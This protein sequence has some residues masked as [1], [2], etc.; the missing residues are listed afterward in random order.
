MENLLQTVRVAARGLR[1]ARAFSLAAIATLALGIGFSTAVFTVANALLLRPLPVV[2]QDRLVVLSGQPR[3]GRPDHYPLGLDQAVDFAKDARSLAGVAAYAYEGASAKPIRDGGDI[4]RLRR[5]LV[6]GDYFA[7]LGA[8]PVLGRQ[9]RPEDDVTGAAPVMVLSHGAWRERFGGSSEVIGRQVVMHEDGT[10]YTIVGVMP[11]GLDFPRGAEAWATIRAATPSGNLQY[12]AV[13]PIARLAPGATASTAAAELTA[14]FSRPGSPAWQG[15]LRG[16]ARALPEIL[17]GDTRPA[18]LVF[19]AAA[20]LLLLI[21]CINVANL[22]VVRGIGRTQEVAIRSALGA[23]QGRI[24]RQLLVEHS[25]LAIAG[26][27]LGLIVAAGAVQAFVDLAPS[28]IPRL[29]EIRL[30]A[31]ALAAALGLTLV[32]MLLFGLAPAIAS[33]RTELQ[34]VLRA[35]ARRSPTRGSRLATEALVVGQVA[36][37]FI[38]LA[39]AGLLARSFIALQRADLA[40]EASSL[41]VA[42]L[43]LRYDRYDTPPKQRALLETLLPEIAALPGVEA[44]TPVVAVPF[45]GTQGWDGK[46]A[47][48]G[49]SPE[50]ARANPMLNMEVVAPTYFETFGLPVLRGRGF[51][52][53]DRAGAPTSAI[54]SESA[55]EFYW[56]DED[57]IGKRLTLGPAGPQQQVMT[58]VGVV[59][60]TRYRDLRDAR[61]S[62]YFPLRQSFF[63]F[64]PTTLV[65]RSASG[66]PSL[67]PALQRVLDEVAPGVGLASVA[68]FT[69]FY[70]APLAQPRLNALLLAAFSAAAVILAA[71]GLFGVMATMVRQRTHELGVRMALGATSGAVGSLVMR[72]GLALA[73]L[74]TAIGLAGAIATG[75]LLKSLLFD[76]QPTDALTL[77]GVALV[78]LAVAAIASALPARASAR[79]APAVALRAD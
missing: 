14:F 50:E 64:T 10:A 51:T 46:L 63:P 38:V 55:A 32:A 23:G 68:P 7:V 48:E 75:R 22:L 9:L 61:M 77:G 78:L 76:V 67:R 28:T 41:E 3:D 44:V 53:D 24:V 27:A 71:V 33:A 18:V 21:T 19:A 62:I 1:L 66:A 30:D 79:I 29:D 65:I 70:E 40:F 57:P 31:T 52:D 36:L 56:P 2:A 49:Q 13:Q 11:R 12:V 58:I 59:P 69:K 47:A 6:S 60:E 26:G 16:V 39:S 54:L 37:A 5:A 74:G 25:L 20:A 45:S 17:L 72:R 8:R 15:D 34:D 4:S 35:G 42:E 43:A 73:A